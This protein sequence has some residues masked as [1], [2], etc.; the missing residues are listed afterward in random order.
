MKTKLLLKTLYLGVLAFGINLSAAAQ[1]CSAVFTSANAGSPGLYNFAANTN[2]NVHY[3]WTVNHV[4]AGNGNKMSHQFNKNGIQYVCLE[5]TDSISNCHDV[6]CDT[7]LVND[8]VNNGPDCKATFYHIDSSLLVHF[9][10]N[11]SIY[12]P[13]ANL[14]WSIDGQPVIINQSEFVFGFANAGTYHVCFNIDD[15]ITNCS[16][17]YC[18]SIVVMDNGNPNPNPDTSIKCMAYVDNYTVNGNEYTFYAGGK[19][20][21]STHF[22]WTVYTPQNSFISYSGTP[23]TVNLPISGNYNICLTIVDSLNNCSDQAC[24][25][26]Y[27]GDTTNACN[28]FFNTN[29]NGNTATYTITSNNPSFNVSS[30]SSVTWSFGDGST[31]SFKSPNIPASVSH[32]YA[33]PGAYATCLT[34]IVDSSCYNTFCD[35]SYVGM[36]NQVTCNA[37]FIVWQDSSNTGAWYGY[38]VPNGLT[39]TGYL[40][41]FGDGTTSTDQFPTHDYAVHGHYT[42]CLTVYDSANNCSDTYCDSSSVHKIKSSGGMSSFSVKNTTNSI[43]TNENYSTISAYPNPATDVVTV[44]IHSKEGSSVY[45]QLYDVFGKLIMNQK[46]NIVKGKNLINLNISELPSGVYFINITDSNTNKTSTMKIV[47]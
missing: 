34:T 45:L 39:Y 3:T 2:S 46:S 38:N 26:M 16:S 37:Y 10:G 44:N 12:S 18:D 40:W 35:S 42:I 15:P 36:N 1:N 47:K 19:H 24:T 4:Y 13:S 31:V 33:Q 41:N 28:N 6:Q 32:Q 27:L 17:S 7:V 30:L 11:A 9:Y 29:A 14:T 25:Q 43:Q 5:T 22:Y 23:F 21:A 8:I 20:T